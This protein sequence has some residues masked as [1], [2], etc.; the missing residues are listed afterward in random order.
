MFNFEYRDTSFAHKDGFSSSPRDEFHKHMHHFIEFIYFECGEV[1]FHVEGVCQRLS[2]G[3][4]VLVQ[5][6]KFHFADVNRDAPYRRYVCK[7][8]EDLLPF[9]LRARISSYH[10]FFS[11][12]ERLLPLFQDLDK[13]AEEFSCS[14]DDMQA[15]CVAK[16][17]E[18]LIRL[19][20]NKNLPIEEAKDTYVSE[21]VD[22]IEAHLG[23]KLTLRTISD[24]FHYSPSYVA[25]TFRK[26]MHVSLISYVRGK[27]IMAAHS[28]ISHGMKPSEAAAAMGFVDYSTFFRCYQKLFGVAPSSAKRGTIR[29]EA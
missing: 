17:V 9:Y 3:D 15:L 29:G 6:G 24:A 5:P 10:P 7:I 19:D 12:N 1:D 27:K 21:L 18:I 14:D 28:L 8:P 25:T 2:P 23:D 22:Y 16:A 4:I 11:S 20:V 26:Q 13:Y